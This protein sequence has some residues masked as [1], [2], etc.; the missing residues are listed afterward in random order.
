[1]LYASAQHERCCRYERN[2]ADIVEEVHSEKLTA[3]KSDWNTA[4]I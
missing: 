3:D 1:V 2:S 4:L